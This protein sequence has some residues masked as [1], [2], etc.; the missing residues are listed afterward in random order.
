MEWKFID[1]S[2]YNIAHGGDDD[3]TT[4]QT[5]PLTKAVIK[6]IKQ[7]TPLIKSFTF[8]LPSPIPYVITLTR[9]YLFLP[10]D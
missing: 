3:G 4:K 2:P 10:I 7:E 5:A 9:P 6:E 1:Y 8:K